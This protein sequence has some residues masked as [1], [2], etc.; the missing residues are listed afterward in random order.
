MVLRERAIE[1]A[2]RLTTSF[3]SA[4]NDLPCHRTAHPFANWFYP[5]KLA[6]VLFSARTMVQ[7]GFTWPSATD[8]VTRQQHGRLPIG[9]ASATSI[10]KHS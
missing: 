7:S 6:P 2:L 4:R 9:S 8:A 1:H 5:E 10:L 3:P